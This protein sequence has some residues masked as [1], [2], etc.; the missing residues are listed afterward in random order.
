MSPAWGWLAHVLPNPSGMAAIRGI[1]FFAG[2]GTGQA[3]LTL[4]WYGA[5]G[6]VVMLLMALV[7]AARKRSKASSGTKDLTS[8]LVAEAGSGAIL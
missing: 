6:V 2:Y 3:F 8:D 4:G 5:A 7:P 1:E